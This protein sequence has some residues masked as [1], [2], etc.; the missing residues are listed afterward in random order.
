ME[1]SGGAMSWLD[2]V[3]TSVVNL[4]GAVGTIK[5]NLKGPSTSDETEAARVARIQSAATS[6][7]VIWII[8]GL[9]VVGVLVLA[10]RK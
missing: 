9:C 7:P 6:L 3:T 5:A 4:S 1:N 2:S 8:G 10:M